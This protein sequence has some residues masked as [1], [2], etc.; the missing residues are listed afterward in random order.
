MDDEERTIASLGAW[1][2]EYQERAV[3]LAVVLGAVL[4]NV[5]QRERLLMARALR[6]AAENGLS[7]LSPDTL[8]VPDRVRLTPEEFHSRIGKRLAEAAR[9]LES[10][11]QIDFFTHLATSKERLV[12]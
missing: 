5:P 6:F 12:P 8:M 11:Q 3:V 9:H 10:S 7:A 1:L 4:T 2:S